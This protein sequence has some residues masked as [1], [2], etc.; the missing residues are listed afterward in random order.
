MNLIRD[1]PLI[2]LTGPTNVPREVLHAM[3]KPM[4]NYRG[5][6]FHKLYL[7]LQEKLMKVL[8]TNN[9]VVIFT[10]SGTGGVEAAL[11]NFLKPGE[12]LVMP[13]YGLFCQRA[14]ETALKLGVEVRTY[15]LGYG[16][17]PTLGFVKTMLAENP[18]A[19][20]IF[21]VFNETS[22]GV[23]VRDL[24]D[25]C[26]EAKRQGMLTIVDAIS[27][28]GGDHLPID[29]WNIDVCITSTQ[30]C[31]AAPPGISL[32]SVS[33][34]ALRAARKNQPRTSYF[35]IP[36]YIDR[37]KE[38]KETPFT[39]VLPLFYALDEA[40]NLI[41]KEG[42]EERFR[43]HQRCSQGLYAA[44]ESMGLEALARE[45]CRS[46]VVV[47]V[48]YPKGIEDGDFRTLLK[49][50]YGIVVSG[51]LGPMEGKIFRIGSMGTISPQKVVRTI[52]A[53]SSCLNRLG[54]KNDPSSALKVAVD[55]LT[56][57]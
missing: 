9:H 23:I 36:L 38:R 56:P 22:S 21:I 55:H 7:S 57:I 40:L 20:A 51:G 4:I 3:I 37:L 11:L 46:N 31:L 49:K 33:E 42:L 50:D 48:R 26:R 12:R 39:P 34:E 32:V 16:K 47:A 52:L 45:E 17:A 5:E 30:K 14:A 15:G 6:E 1:E 29:E 54:F 44:V 2:M 35:N 28:L 41:M 8:M 13:V 18:E 24:R 27:V 53:I 19:K 43:R 10:S 25:I